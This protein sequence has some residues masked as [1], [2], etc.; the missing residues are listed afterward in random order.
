MK[1]IVLALLCV[2]GISGLASF[3]NAQENPPKYLR[4]L[5][6]GERFP[7]KGQLKNGVIVGQ[8]PPKGAE[9]PKDT[10]LVSGDQAVPFQLGLRTFTDVLTIAGSTKKLILRSGE[11]DAQTTWFSSPKP[12]ASL[13]LAVL[14]PDPATMLWNNPRMLLL[15]DGPQSFKPGEIRFVNITD[16][17]VLVK[18]GKAGTFKLSPGKTITKS[19]QVGATPALLGYMNGKTPTSIW[20]NEIKVLSNQRVQCF[21]YKVRKPNQREEILS[22]IVQELVP[23]L[24]KP[25]KSE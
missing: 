9:P 8:K 6:L 7:W 11:K 4:I 2:T 16:K 5:A 22:K 15:D 17:A 23:Q 1:I 10:A 13:S 14:S 25:P 18:L 12:K 20:E 24:P 19:I 21:F 3:A